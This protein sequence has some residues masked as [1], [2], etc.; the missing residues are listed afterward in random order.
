MKSR[1]TTTQTPRNPDR[2]PKPVWVQTLLLTTRHRRGFLPWQEIKRE[3]EKIRAI[4]LVEEVSH[5]RGEHPPIRRPPSLRTLPPQLLT[6]QEHQNTDRSWSCQGEKSKSSASLA[7]RLGAGAGDDERV[8]WYMSLMSQCPF[9][10]SS[11]DLTD[12][13]LVEKNKW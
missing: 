3:R 7:S 1:R 2:N 12:G 4:S 11:T 8:R 6:I 9:K 5:T 10:T 13:F